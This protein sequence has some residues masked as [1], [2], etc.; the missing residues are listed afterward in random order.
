MRI[1]DWSSDVCSSDLLLPKVHAYFR[2]RYPDALLKI[3][4]SLFPAAEPEIL[5]GKIDLYA[6]PAAPRT[7]ARARKSVVSGKSVSV[8]VDLGGRRISQKKTDQGVI[9]TQNNNTKIKT[10]KKQD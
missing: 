4:E 10:A 3:S 7:H 2:K 6:G 5:A 1:S 9:N 8:R